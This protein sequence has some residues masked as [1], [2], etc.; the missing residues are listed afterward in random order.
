MITIF[1]IEKKYTSMTIS[2]NMDKMQT[3]RLHFSKIQLILL[4]VMVKNLIALPIM[5]QNDDPIIYNDQINDFNLADSFQKQDSFNRYDDDEELIRNIDKNI[6]QESND[7]P[8]N[9]LEEA[10]D[11]IRLVVK[12]SAVNKNQFQSG[13]GKRIEESSAK[14]QNRL[15]K[16]DKSIQ[17][18]EKKSW[19]IPIKSIA[20]WSDSKDLKRPQ[21]SLESLSQLS[22]ALDS[23]KDG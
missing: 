17:R 8:M 3:R 2:S 21:P 1:D 16:L 18:L 9:N 23:F 12:A 4:I 5:S 15:F 22:K 7:L 10:K 13:R 14:N 19:K 11:L 6:L 20:L